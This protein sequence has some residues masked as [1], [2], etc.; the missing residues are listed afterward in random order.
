MS[1]FAGGDASFVTT[2]SA[3]TTSGFSTPTSTATQPAVV[4]DASSPHETNVAEWMRTPE[5]QAHAGRWV[6]LSPE[7]QVLDS[8]E[9]PSELLARDAGEVAPTIVLVD[10]SAKQYAL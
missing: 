5:A 1:F 10:P 3:V 8:S 9:S 2:G 6:L 4:H 7:L